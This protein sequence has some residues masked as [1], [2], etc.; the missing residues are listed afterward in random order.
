MA[1]CDQLG[2]DLLHC[3][4]LKSLQMKLFFQISDRFQES[5]DFLKEI[6]L[7]SRGILTLPN[8]KFYIVG[9]LN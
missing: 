2:V 3:G 6:V 7:H 8:M 4:E 9:N 5:L 1:N